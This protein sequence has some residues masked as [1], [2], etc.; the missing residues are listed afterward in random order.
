MSKNQIKKRLETAE[1]TRTP[2][3]DESN[4][5]KGTFVSGFEWQHSDP[6]ICRALPKRG[7]CG[8]KVKIYMYN[9]ADSVVVFNAENLKLSKCGFCEHI[10]R[11]CTGAN[12]SKFDLENIRKARRI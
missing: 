4:L 10:L 11:D 9:P 1:F 6:K 2:E 3:Q 7:Y 12:Y 8:V 5:P